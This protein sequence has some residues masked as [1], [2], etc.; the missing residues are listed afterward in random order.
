MFLFLLNENEA[1]GFIEL[2]AKS[3]NDLGCKKT[4][5]LSE[6]GSFYSELNLDDYKVKN[7]EMAEIVTILRDSSIHVKRAIIIE[8]CGFIYAINKQIKDKEEKWIGNLSQ[9][10]DIPPEQ[11]SRLL[12]WSKDF[13]DFLE[14]GLMYINAK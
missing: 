5:E 12:R 10:L 1:K 11:M 13:S 3:L 4:E 2:A 6:L 9:S 14:I 7:L 8:I